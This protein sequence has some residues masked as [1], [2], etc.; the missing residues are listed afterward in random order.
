MVGDGREFA[1]IDEGN[2]W[3]WVFGILGVKDD[4]GRQVLRLVKRRGWEHLVPIVVR[5][6]CPGTARINDECL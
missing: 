4:Q 2:F 6:V 1:L 5:H 3:K